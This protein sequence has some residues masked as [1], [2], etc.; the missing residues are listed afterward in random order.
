MM[1]LLLLMMHAV[2]IARLPHGH[3]SE[4]PDVHILIVLQLLQIRHDLS[5]DQLLTPLRRAAVH[6][7]GLLKREE[8]PFRWK[9]SEDVDENG[10][11]FG[12]VETDIGNIVRC[13][14]VH[15]RQD[16]FLNNI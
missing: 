16:R 2:V 13:E 11:G 15:H 8:S 7:A 12:H 3:R 10:V 9:T 5:L 4:I 14:F 1:L 6:D